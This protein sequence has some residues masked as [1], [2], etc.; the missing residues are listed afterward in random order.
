M[1]TS[2]AMRRFWLGIIAIACCSLT[3]AVASATILIDHFS[4][5]GNGYTISLGN[6][7][8]I[9][10]G[11]NNLDGTMGW[12]N[13]VPSG[14]R[15]ITVTAFNALKNQ[16]FY[17]ASGGVTGGN[18]AFGSSSLHKSDPGTEA[19]LAYTGFPDHEILDV[20]QGGTNN[21]FL[22]SF[23]GNDKPFTVVADVYGASGHW[24][25]TVPVTSTDISDL[26]IPFA[27]FSPVSGSIS[28]SDLTKIA[29]TFNPDGEVPN[30]DF[31]LSSIVAT[32]FVPEP[33][34]VALL[35]TGVAALL[36]AA[37]RRR[38]REG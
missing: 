19:V 5:S 26:S 14:N 4:N 38:A 17:A 18:Y 20:S 22:L 24:T 28:F 32:N 8:G 27:L 11:T 10:D 3:P 37:R 34:T 2:I 9:Y 25:A 15:Q 6:S 33:G 31:A 13:G 36:L 1:N 29:F 16:Y 21:R 23:D 30:L 7:T 12:P 35:S